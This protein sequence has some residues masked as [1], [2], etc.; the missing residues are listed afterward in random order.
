MIGIGYVG[1]VSG[2]CEPPLRLVVSCLLH[3]GVPRGTF[4]PH[5]GN[6]IRL[7]SSGGLIKPK[8]LIAMVKI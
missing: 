2:A 5:G 7:K 4:A 8:A 6:L 3:D 1:L